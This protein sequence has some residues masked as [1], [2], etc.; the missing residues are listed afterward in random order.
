MSKDIYSKIKKKLIDG[1]FKYLLVWIMYTMGSNFANH[2]D[3]V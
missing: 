1:G 2:K 3:N